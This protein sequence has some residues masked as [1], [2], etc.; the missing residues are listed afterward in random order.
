M[1]FGRTVSPFLGGPQMARF[2]TAGAF[3][4]NVPHVPQMRQDNGG[5]LAVDPAALA[6]LVRDLRERANQKTAPAAPAGQGAAYPGG[7]EIH[8]VPD[9]GN[10]IPPMAGPRVP[11]VREWPGQIPGQAAGPMLGPGQPLT[12]SIPGM[13]A[14][15]GAGAGRMDP[16]TLLMLLR[17]QQSTGGGAGAADGGVSPL[18][19]GGLLGLMG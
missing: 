9:Y 4:G 12:P 11:R 13:P 10:G 6:A 15:M 2:Q 7:P 5:G 8:G 16:A 14:E 3:G 18:A 17:G 1:A 19:M